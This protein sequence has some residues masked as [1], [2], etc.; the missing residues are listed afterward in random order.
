MSELL[1]QG[2]IIGPYEITGTL[3]KGGMGEVYRARDHRLGREL[4]LKL[5][6]PQS[7]GDAQAVERFIREARAASALNHPNVVTIYEIG[8]AAAG[9]F[10]AMELVLGETLRSLTSEPQPL[11]LL[12]HIASQIA[13]A[14]AVAH[15]AGIVHRDI[16]PENVMV[17]F[18]GY[19]KVLDF[20]IAR[21][22][23]ARE[24]GPK[25]THA[26]PTQTGQAVGTLRYMSPEQAC[27]EPVTGAT[28]IFSFGLLLHELATGRHPFAAS[29]ASSDMALVSAILTAPAPAASASNALLS[30]GFDALLLRML[31]KEPKRRPSAAEVDLALRELSTVEHPVPRT[32]IALERNTVGRE[33]E[34]I[35]LRQAFSN[36]DSGHGVLLSI[37]GEPGM[38]KSTLVDEFLNVLSTNTRG[39][40]V[41]RGRC[42]ERLAGSEAYLPILEALDSLMHGADSSFVTTTLKRFAPTWYVQ[43]APGVV[44]DS[45]EARAL[46]SVQASSQERLKRELATFLAEV[47]RDRPIV[48]FLDDLHWADTSTIDVL[49][50]VGARLST[51]RMMV[52]VTVRPAELLLAKHPYAQLK[53]DLQARGLCR[54]L[55]LEFLTPQDVAQYL[56]LECRG[57]AFPPDFAALIHAKTEGSPLFMADLLRYLQTRGVIAN[58]DG[59]YVLTQ[60]VPTIQL[61]LPESIR[62]MI[63]RKIEQLPDADRRLLAAASVQGYVFDSAIV[64]NL[65]ATDPGDVE[66]RLEALEHVFGFVR[67]LEERELP[68]GTLNVRYRFLHLLYQNALYA[69][70][71]PTRRVSL[72]ER[73]AL[74]LASGYGNRTPEIAAELALLFEA[75]RDQGRA[76]EY[77]IVAAQAAARVFAN[78][79]GVMLSERALHLLS[80]LPDTQVRAEQEL[81]IQ[82]TYATSLGA[83]KGLAFPDVGKAFARAYELWKQLGARPELF[84][85]LGGLWGYHIVAAKLDVALAIGEE[86][87]SIATSVGARAMLAAAH[88]TLALTWHHLG[89]HRKAMEHFEQG[90][91]LY[92]IDLS[93]LFVSLPVEPGVSLHAESSRVLWI[94]GYPDRALERASGALAL[95]ELVPHPEARGFAPLFAAFVYHFRGDVPNTLRQTETVL[96]LARERDIATTLAWGLVVH[97][98]ALVKQGDVQEGLSEMRGSLAAQ[99]AAGCLIARPQFLAI[100]ADACRHAGRYDDALAATREGLECSATTGDCYWDSELQ[101]LRG[102]VLNHIGAD[103]AEINDC[104]ERSLAD[105]RARGAR[106]FELRSATSAARFATGH[107]NHSQAQSALSD[108]LV[109][110]TEGLDTADL[111]EARS[112]LNTM[113]THSLDGAAP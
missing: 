43:L 8:E 64:A 37:A 18:D 54:E 86:L 23:D 111:V 51:L 107:R 50:Y 34:M 30:A 67:R 110:F 57:H 91:Q 80:N 55:I 24:G 106:S 65:T 99:L 60:S 74:A 14:L 59:Y 83:I 82:S 100:L 44:E 49:A 25:L 52:L 88:N 39:A 9:R 16:K 90:L 53:L 89:D 104:F 38:G 113:A 42:S 75:A 5:L 68:D 87:L 4:A 98:W 11:T 102:E 41:A 1:A 95:A 7:G 28:D 85:V 96:A 101:R 81:L 56:Q 58:T 17:R 15:A 77:L 61:E 97:G 94:M 47:S 32:E 62:S 31:D 20:G 22:L 6:S 29:G 26:V 84:P 72:S 63:Q 10:I 19:V 108:I 36:A 71:T 112:V 33:R 76:V 79:E 109:S 73:A 93:P 103:R 66:E 13:R 12:V 45:A 48:L 78:Q 35:T 27:A 21:L 2:D 46:V 3:G 69:G 40:R 105:A 92:S 70:L